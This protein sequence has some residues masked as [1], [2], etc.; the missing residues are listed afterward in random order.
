M[1]EPTVRTRYAPLAPR[2]AEVL[3]LIAGGFTD[4]QIGAQLGVTAAS[5]RV[6]A[7]RLIEAY[8]ATG[9]AHMIACA[10]RQGD[11]K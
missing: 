2:L 11:L 8:S 4:D 10:F 6:F 7:R 5:V 9:R 1:S 3:P